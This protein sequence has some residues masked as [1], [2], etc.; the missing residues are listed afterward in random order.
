MQF[1]S[2]SSVHIELD[3]LQLGGAP[4]FEAAR[5]TMDAHF[6][7]AQERL[8]DSDRN[9]KDATKDSPLDFWGRVVVP[10]IAIL[11]LAAKQ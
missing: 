2:A 11:G 5:R 9:I 3:N 4:R 6:A 8:D 1:R 7:I 10:R